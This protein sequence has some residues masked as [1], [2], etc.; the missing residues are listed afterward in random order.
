LSGSTVEGK[1][2]TDR[3][4]T[5]VIASCA[6]GINSNSQKDPDSEFGRQ[7]SNILDFSVL[8][9]LAMLRVFLHRIFSK[10]FGWK[11]WMINRR[12]IWGKSCGVQWST[13]EKNIFLR[14]SFNDKRNGLLGR[15]KFSSSSVHRLTVPRTLLL[16]TKKVCNP[17]VQL[18]LTNHFYLNVEVNNISNTV[19][20]FWYQNNF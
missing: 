20:V 2:T 13:G 15:Q 14:I 19:S 6:F 9:G 11:S 10:Y 17:Q 1:R 18:H 4:T 12:I 16:L 7:I 3:F 5:D 8:K